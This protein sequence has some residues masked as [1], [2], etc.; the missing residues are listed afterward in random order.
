[1]STP[2]GRNYWKLWTAS[3]ISNFGDGVAIIA[4]PWLASSVTRDP[5]QIALVAVATRLPW[6]VFT[7]PAGV[8]TDRVDRRKLV[9]WMD[10]VRFLI[11]MGIAL[12]V[13]TIQDQLAT[14]DEIAAG[15]AALPESSTL[16]LVMIY[17]AALLLGTAEVLRDNSAQTLLPAIVDEENLERANGRL[18][19]AEVVM[20]SFV[21]PP[22]GGFLLAV[23]FALPFFVDAGTFA[24]AA[25][26]MFTIGG[27]FKARSTSPRPEARVSFLAEMKEGFHWLWRHPLFRPMAISLGVLNAMDTLALSTFVLFVQEILDLDAA[28]FGALM[29]AGAAG[30]VVGSLVAA[31]VS[32]RIGQGASL[33]LTVATG[34]VTFLVL[35]LTSSAVVMWAM[36]ALMTLTGTLWNVI[37]VSLRQALI[38]DHLLGRVNSVYRFFGWGMMPI[39]SVL[40]GVIVAITEPIAEREW[41][42]RAPFIFAAIVHVGLLFYAIPN[43]NSSRIEEARA[44]AK[45]QGSGVEPIEG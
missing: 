17:A 45:I 7:L 43:L 5:V 29:T 25:A 22:L 16:L 20:N 42:L 18:W 1:M 6:L 3:V 32:K 13:L 12:T 37:T 2:L 35:G 9:A 4:Y 34:V 33:F 14:P 11:T 38:P 39:G 31:R 21:G 24:V 8:I 15:T 44:M 27:E 28:G 19:G 41:A 10:V 30:G 36:F 26:L 23:A 40:G